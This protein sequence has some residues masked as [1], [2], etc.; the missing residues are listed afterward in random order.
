MGE[1]D[2][3]ESTY[4]RITIKADGSDDVDLNAVVAQVASL[5]KITNLSVETY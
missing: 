3:K 5:G 4:I 1:E 2:Y